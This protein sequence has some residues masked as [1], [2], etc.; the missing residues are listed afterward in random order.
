[1][2]RKR[3]SKSAFDIHCGEIHADDGVDPAEFFR[4]SHRRN[5]DRRKAQQLCHQVADTL[6]LVLSG[7]FGEELG[8]LRVAE[9][10]PAP[11]TTQLLVLLT[12][13]V[14]SA[15]VDRQ[16][17]ANRLAAAAGRLRSEVAASI[18]RKRAPRLLFELIAGGPAEAQS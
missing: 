16:V 9:V 18:T 13:V 8:D 4:P 14:A 6:N 7:E 5:S 10:R 12:P 2:K 11:D 3:A 1:M 17:V 15:I